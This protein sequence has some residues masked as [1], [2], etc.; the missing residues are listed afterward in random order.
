[1]SSCASVLNCLTE[2]D[3]SKAPPI[4]FMIEEYEMS[5]V[6]PHNA[7]TTPTHT[8]HPRPVLKSP[9]HTIV[10]Q[11]PRPLV[12][13]SYHHTLLPGNSMVS[14]K[15]SIDK[16][17]T[18]K[19]SLKVNVKFSYLKSPVQS[20]IGTSPWSNE[21]WLLQKQPLADFKSCFINPILGRKTKNGTNG[22]NRLTINYLR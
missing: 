17:M 4:R 16:G 18:N 3:L 1:M 5:N 21:I 22:S 15:A 12:C 19:N 9:T 2:L 6:I 20:G 11:D 10:G 13:L 8:N 14:L 7:T